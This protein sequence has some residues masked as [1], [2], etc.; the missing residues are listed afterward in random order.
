MHTRLRKVG[1]ITKITTDNGQL[2]VKIVEDGA[3]VLDPVTMRPVAKLGTRDAVQI[4]KTVRSMSTFLK[5]KRN[6]ETLGVQMAPDSL[7]L[8]MM[9]YDGKG[10]IQDVTIEERAEIEEALLAKER[11]G[12]RKPRNTVIPVLERNR[13]R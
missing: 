8:L 7:D 10:R 12:G 3:V 9:Q 4:T 5:H 6:L 13:R 2:I 1:D 11:E